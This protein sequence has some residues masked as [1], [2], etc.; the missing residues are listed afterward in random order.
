M[1]YVIEIEVDGGCRFQ[2]S[3]DAIAAAAAV[4]VFRDGRHSAWTQTL[5]DSPPPT[6]QRAKIT[7][8]ILAL[9]LALAEADKLSSDPYVETRILSDSKY[10]IG[11]M[12]EW[13]KKWVKNGWTNA[14]GNPVA[15]QDLIRQARDLDDRVAQLGKV[16]YKWIPRKRNET[17]DLYCNRELDDMM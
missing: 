3:K 8:I 11:C 10:A 6:N 16:E 5:P 7:A 14:V 9:E 15:N 12:N 17:A 4:R 13:I 2:G 1:V